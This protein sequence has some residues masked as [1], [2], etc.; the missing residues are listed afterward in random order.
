MAFVILHLNA[1]N[2]C[3]CCESRKRT[4]VCVYN[5]LLC[6][7]VHFNFLR[8]ISC[9]TGCRIAEYRRKKTHTHTTIRDENRRMQNE[10]GMK[11]TGSR[12]ESSHRAYWKLCCVCALENLHIRS[13]AYLWRALFLPGARATTRPASLLHLASQPLCLS[14]TATYNTW[15][16]KQIHA[17]KKNRRKE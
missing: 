11:K 12:K 1:E 10:N 16:Q 9:S 15:N 5:S 4:R 14:L 17:R 3:M 2:W 6:V 8:Y 13:V 7:C